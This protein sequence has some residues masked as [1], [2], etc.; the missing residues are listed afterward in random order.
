MPRAR[1]AK[2]REEKKKKKVSEKYGAL[3]SRRHTFDHSPSHVAKRREEKGRTYKKSP[4]LLL[5]EL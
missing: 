4:S 1:R 2:N 3:I 5:L